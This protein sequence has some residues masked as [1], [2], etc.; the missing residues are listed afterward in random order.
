MFLYS[1]LGIGLAIFN[2]VKNTNTVTYLICAYRQA[3][4]RPNPLW[5]S[6]YNPLKAAILHHKCWKASCVKMI[7]G[8]YYQT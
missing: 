7:S 8:Y 1:C 6:L 5:Q 3:C 4:V 2:T